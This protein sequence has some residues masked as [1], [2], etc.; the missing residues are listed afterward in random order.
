MLINIIKK[1]KDRLHFPGLHYKW[2]NSEAFQGIIMSSIC[3]SAIP[4]LT[5][6]LGISF[7]L[8]WSLVIINGLL[9]NFHS[10]FGDVLV[11]G[12]ITPSIPLIILY[13]N[14][15][16]L[17]DERILALIVVQIQVAVIFLV[18]GYT[19]LSE[20]ITK[21]IPLPLKAGI[22]L[23][24]GFASIVGEFK[25][26]GRIDLYPTSIFFGSVFCCYILFSTRFECHKRKYNLLKTIGKFGILPAIGISLI[27]GVIFNE[28]QIPTVTFTELIKIPD[29]LEIYKKM[30]ILTLGF[31]SIDY[32]IKGIP[33]SILIYIIAV[34]DLITGEIIINEANQKR[35]DK[36]IK[37]NSN[38]SCILSGIR[39]LFQGFFA[40]FLPMSGPLAAA[41][42][43]TI[44]ERY[45]ENSSM[46]N[47]LGGIGT[48]RIVTLFSIMII[49][50][51]SF[52]QPI[53]PVALSLTL[54]IQGYI[55]TKLGMNMC[56]NEFEMGVAG[57]VGGILLSRGALWGLSI[58]FFIYYVIGNE[59]R[60]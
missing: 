19:G 5:E 31:P 35:N 32:F 59:S 49:P 1:S 2:E 21:S 58:G 13:L 50:I 22:L 29:L 54:L 38:I 44:V 33:I 47:L 3:L 36:N 28:I 16:K 12:W 9:Y 7:D 48:Y 39:N 8:A 52:V 42:T 34:G 40:P 55:C 45:K 18:M 41:M 60:V 46:K 10:I 51:V 25:S 56:K 17:G 4:I 20:K 26:G 37:F 14:N 15:F 53:L 43:V 57:I 30:S 24:A 6:T 11:P 23:A 27:I